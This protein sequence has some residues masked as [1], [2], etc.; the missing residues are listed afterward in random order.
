MRNSRALALDLPARARPSSLASC[1]AQRLELLLTAAKQAGDSS[2]RYAPIKKKTMDDFKKIKHLYNRAGF[3]LPPSQY[4]WAQSS[5]VEL[6]L[7]TLV[8]KPKTMDLMSEDIVEKPTVEAFKGASKEE[9]RKMMKALRRQVKVVNYTFLETLIEGENPFLERMLLFWHGHFACGPK[10]ADFAVQY[11]NALKGNALGNFRDLVV[12]VSKSAAMIAYLNNQQNK[13]RKPN[14]NF[15]RELMELFT[16]GRG[17]YTEQDIKE[18]ARAFTGWFSNRMTGDFQFNKRQHDGEKKTF[19]GRTGHFDGEDIIDIILE[20][21]EVAFFIAYKVYRYF[22]STDINEAHVKELALVF[23]KS[24]YNILQM[25]R[26][27]FSQNW[28]Y[29][30]S[31]IGTKI[32]SPIDLIVG[33]GKQLGLRFNTQK[34][35]S[36]TQHALGQKLLSPPNV[37]GWPVGQVWIDN[38]TLMVRL[39]FVAILFNKAS[40]D[41]KI[42]DE[43]EKI[44]GRG[45][46]KLH[47]AID[48]SKLE[49]ILGDASVNALASYLIAPEYQPDTA[50]LKSWLKD[51]KEK[52]FN[53]TLILLCSLPEF[54]LA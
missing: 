28:F 51:D 43:P 9:R 25:M 34:A 8:K 11:I 41:F 24:N 23:K 15:A 26:F 50:Y 12:E 45:L 27:L 7:K 5:S 32:K 16:I 54:Q 21:E 44:R 37:A 35:A 42:K 18:A 39:N 49:K 33:L 3:G 36:Y 31:I 53:R 48:L 10:R 22:V 2:S 13:K 19:M 46:K 40:I 29:S 20:Q 30:P 4:K 1:V 17:N 14:E 47:I 6:A 38:A 52:A